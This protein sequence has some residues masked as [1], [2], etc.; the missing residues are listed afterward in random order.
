VYKELG[1]YSKALECLE[2]AYIINPDD[3]DIKL[4]LEVVRQKIFEQK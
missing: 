3:E 2:R 4:G 1:Y